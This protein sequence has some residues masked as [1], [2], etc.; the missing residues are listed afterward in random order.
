M[1]Y[2]PFCRS[3]AVTQVVHT[4]TVVTAVLLT[5][6][7]CPQLLRTRSTTAVVP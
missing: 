6:A 5:H 3:R 4:R 2:E 7:P 1:D